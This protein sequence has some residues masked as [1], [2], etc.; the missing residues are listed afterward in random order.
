MNLALAYEEPLTHWLYGAP[1]RAVAL[2]GPLPL[3]FPASFAERLHLLS[4]H[5]EISEEVLGHLYFDLVLS[6]Q[7]HAAMCRMGPA[8]VCTA[9]MPHGD[10]IFLDPRFCWAHHIDGRLGQRWRDCL[11]RHREDKALSQVIALLS[12]FRILAEHL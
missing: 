11:Q 9:D 5:P 6:P 7:L 2:P 10:S 1:P 12:G 4:H 3:G 8:S